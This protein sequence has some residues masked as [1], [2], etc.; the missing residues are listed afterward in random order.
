M[1]YG[2]AIIVFFIALVATVFLFGQ[3][4]PRA[5]IEWLRQKSWGRELN[6]I[7]MVGFA[8]AAALIAF[9]IVR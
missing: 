6:G 4:M 8:V 7:L 9:L 3:F 1:A 5:Y 2:V